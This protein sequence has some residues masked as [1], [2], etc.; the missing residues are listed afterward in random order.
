VDKLVPVI[1]LDL[2][3][4]VRGEYKFKRTHETTRHRNTRVRPATIYPIHIIQYAVDPHDRVINIAKLLEES[5]QKDNCGDAL[6]TL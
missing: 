3:A 5:P 6:V 2:S 4:I 1:T